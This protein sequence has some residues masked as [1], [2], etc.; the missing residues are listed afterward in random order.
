VPLACRGLATLVMPN[1]EGG[2]SQPDRVAGR[3]ANAQRRRYSCLR[4]SGTFRHLAA[5]SF[6]PVAS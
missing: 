2:Q 1:R 4:A 6:L 5:S 3:S